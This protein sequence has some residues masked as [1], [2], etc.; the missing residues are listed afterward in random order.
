MGNDDRDRT[1]RA[2]QVAFD[3]WERRNTADPMAGPLEARGA[4]FADLLDE[5]A[6]GRPWMTLGGD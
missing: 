3:E 6:G 5:L 1:A 2:F 4:Y